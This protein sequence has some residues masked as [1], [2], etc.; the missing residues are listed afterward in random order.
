MAGLDLG[1]HAASKLR[2]R[3]EALTAIRAAIDADDAIM[4]ASA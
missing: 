4:R 2:A 3:D 1:A